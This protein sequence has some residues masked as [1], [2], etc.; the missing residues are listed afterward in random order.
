MT[1]N[2][3]LYGVYYHNQNICAVLILKYYYVQCKGIM[4]LWNYETYIAQSILQKHNIY[5]LEF[6]HTSSRNHSKDQ[7][8]NC[9]GVSD[10]P[11]VR[12][13][14]PYDNRFRRITFLVSEISCASLQQHPFLSH[15]SIYTTMENICHLYPIPKI[16]HPKASVDFRPI[17][18]TPVL[19]HP[20]E[21]IIIWNF[22][23]QPRSAINL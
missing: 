8:R 13:S 5:W 21:K 2:S 22:V 10:F 17:S 23:Y 12:L 4:R 19:T 7:R 18:I 20:L 16:P 6:R 14:S 9:Q 15:Q 11:L 1:T 3:L